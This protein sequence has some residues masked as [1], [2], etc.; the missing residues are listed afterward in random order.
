MK[1]CFVCTG[2][3]CRSPMAQGIA[4]K[5]LD[6]VNGVEITSAGLS[7]FGGDAPSPEAV[8][9]AKEYGADISEHRSRPLSRYELE[10]TDL[11]VCMTQC[12][13][14]VLDSFSPHGKTVVLGAGISDPYG[15]NREVY[16]RCARE[17]YNLLV[18][19]CKRI[20]SEAECVSVIRP[21]SPADIPQMEEIERQ[22]FHVPWSRASLSNELD[23]T[24]SHL[25]VSVVDGKLSGYIVVWEIAG[26]ADLLRIA[27][28]P[29]QR[30]RGLGRDL[31][32]AAVKDARARGCTAMT[33]E[34]RASNKAAIGLYKSLGFEQNGLRKNYYS[35]PVEDS[36]LMKLDFC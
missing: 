1:I 8:E 36:V 26:E 23:N 35:S 11:F 17:I 31:V 25:L 10:D 24:N 29:Q 18:P 16:A 12:H 13:K 5:L 32:E 34:V 27:V 2:N 9:A 22:S 19:L 30:R 6:G 28:S 15:G 3:T 20:R 7:A 21:A 14:D 33:L 4:R